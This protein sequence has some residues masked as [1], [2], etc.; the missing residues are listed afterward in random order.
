[1]MPIM[2]TATTR[3]NILDAAERL[4]ASRGF[5]GTSI[6]A[7]T[8]EAGVNVAAVHYHFGTKEEVLRGVTDRVVIPI[9][10][11][12]VELL[13]R[14]VADTAPFPPTVEAILEAFIRPDLVELRRIHKR[15]PA[16]ARLM[17]R[18]YSDQTPWVQAMTREQ[19]SGIQ[20]RFL[21]VLGD[22]LPDL[23]TGEIAWR[24]NRIAAVIVNL[25][26]TWPEEGMTEVQVDATVDRLVTF[27]APGLSAAEPTQPPAGGQ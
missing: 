1:M 25:F 20:Q 9:N 15:G 5:D 4:F 24:M 18:V 21:S 11:T 26:A 6:R 14:A 7:I 8:R 12:R 10:G 13:D 19:F 27:L 23:S 17:G 3:T 16:V 2:S 22:A